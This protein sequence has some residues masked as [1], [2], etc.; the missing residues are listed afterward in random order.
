MQ[1]GQGFGEMIGNWVLTGKLGENATRKMVA[2]V[3]A[4]LAAQSIQ[5]AI[6]HTAMGIAAL[7]PWGAI[8]Y[9]S[10]ILHFK[11]AAMWGAVGV[12]AALAGR[13]V[14]G[15]SFNKTAN[16]NFTSSKI[17]GN[18]T[19]R[20]VSDTT[21]LMSESRIN[22]QEQRITLE[23]MSRDSHIVKVVGDNLNNRGDLHPVVVKLVEA[24]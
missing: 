15:D 11:A 2:S 8:L 6:F 21:N 5:L 4:G 9:G 7:T 1:M 16:T 22:R 12:G 10:P 13:A 3:L 24:N 14:A 18:N 19:S 17:G 23:V 20:S